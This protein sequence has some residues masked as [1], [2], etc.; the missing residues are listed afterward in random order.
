MTK[1]KLSTGAEVEIKKPNAKQLAD[2]Q[3]YS[4]KLFVRLINEKDAGGQPTAI[5][6]PNLVEKMKEFGLWSDEKENRLRK[7][8]DRE[9]EECEKSAASTRSKAA[10]RELA[11]KINKL[12]GEKLLLVYEKNQLDLYTVEAQVENAKFDY[13]V[14]ACVYNDDGTKLYPS[15][16]RYLELSET[17]DASLVATELSK[18]MYGLEENWQDKLP[19]QKIF[20]KLGLV[21]EEG[22]LLEDEKGNKLKTETAAETVNLD[23]VEYTEE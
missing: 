12:R 21:D 17:D 8:I 1:V 2:A 23:D 15:V 18:L 14:S 5:F 16:E 10:A 3:V 19:E 7:E 6:R 9:I 20:K 4:G 13:L 11:F 22:N